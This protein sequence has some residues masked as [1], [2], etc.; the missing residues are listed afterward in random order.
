MIKCRSARR[1]HSTAV[2]GYHSSHGQEVPESHAFLHAR[3]IECTPKVDCHRGYERSLELIPIP[4]PI[5]VPMYSGMGSTTDWPPPDPPLFSETQRFRQS[6]VLLLIGG[7]AFIAWYSFFQQIVCGIPFGN[8]PASDTGVVILF[9][10]LGVFLPIL[11]LFIMR[12]EIQVTQRALWFRF[13]PLHFRWR[14]VPL[15]TIADVKAG[16]YRPMLEYGGWG[17][18]LGIKGVAYTV[19]GDRGVQ[20]T[21]KNRKSFLLGSNRAEEMES[22]LLSVIRK[23]A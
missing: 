12:L 14:E 23:E 1:Y 22:L 7:I 3:I 16:V 8:N 20:V 19:S 9:I 5:P 15:D 18:R 17:I 4:Y 11:F 6:W 13:F 21:L 2:E 10:G